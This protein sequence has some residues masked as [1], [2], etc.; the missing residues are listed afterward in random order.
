[1]PFT[2][3]RLF[4]AIIKRDQSMKRITYLIL[5]IFLGG[6]GY[7]NPYTGPKSTGENHIIHAPM[8]KNQTNEIGLE[9]NIHQAIHDWLSESPIIDLTSSRSEADYILT[10]TIHSIDM[11]GLSYGVFD[12]A[13]EVRAIMEISYELR[14]KSGGTVIF[15]KQKFIKQ[16][17]FKIGA[18]SPRHRTNKESALLIVADEIGEEI[19]RNILHALTKKKRHN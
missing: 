10:G 4:K 13:L 11:P 8:W 3:R 19:Y 7:Y 12:Q 17:A 5:L 18:D 1:M 15:N 6:C 9:A 14:E 2:A 16:K